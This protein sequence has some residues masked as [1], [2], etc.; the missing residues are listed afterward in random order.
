MT[1]FFVLILVNRMKICL[2][3]VEGSSYTKMMCIEFSKSNLEFDLILVK[4]ETESWLPKVL[5]IPYKLYLVANSGRFKGLR[6]YSAYFAR[7]YIKYLARSV[8]SKKYEFENEYRSLGFAEAVRAA[9][10]VYRVPSVNHVKAY[11][12]LKSGGYDLGVLAGVGIVSE[13]ILQ[14]FSQYCLNAHPAPLPFCKGGGALE[15]TLYKDLMP[16]VTIHKAVKEIDGGEILDVVNLELMKN[17]SFDKI[18]RRLTI[19]CC[20]TMAKNVNYLANYEQVEFTDNLG[21]TLHY[22]VDCDERIQKSARKNLKKILE[23]I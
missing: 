2:L 13:L 17:D 15:N 8:F 4:R 20:A 19:L 1:S 18:Y 12:I 10:G 11:S 23:N 6:K 14:S 16:A 3:G 21:G 22:W 9:R 5:Q 7:E